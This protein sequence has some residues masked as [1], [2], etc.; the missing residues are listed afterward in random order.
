MAL[1]VVSN[2]IL[3]GIGVPLDPSSAYSNFLWASRLGHGKAALCAANMLYESSVSSHMRDQMYSTTTA[4][5]IPKR[6]LADDE[7][8]DIN[9]DI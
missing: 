8:T 6:F 4:E 3:Q 5:L 9:S 7:S 1:V 2:G